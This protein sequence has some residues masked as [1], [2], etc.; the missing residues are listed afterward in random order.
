MLLHSVYVKFSTL[1]CTLT[2]TLTLT[3]EVPGAEAAFKRFAR[4]GAT[5]VRV[6]S[7]Y[8]DYTA[9]RNGPTFVGVRVRSNYDEHRHASSPPHHPYVCMIS[10]SDMPPPLPTTPM[11]V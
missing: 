9:I 11:C 3:L 7:M 5:F 8:I 1:T 4:N 2:L 6:M 10:Q